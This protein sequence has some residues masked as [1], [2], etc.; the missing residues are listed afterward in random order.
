MMADVKQ[1]PTK[2][3]VLLI[4]V[5]ILLLVSSLPVFAGSVGGTTNLYHSHSHPDSPAIPQE[6]QRYSC[7]LCHINCENSIISPNRFT[8]NACVDL[9]WGPA[10]R[11]GDIPSAHTETFP[12]DTAQDNLSLPH[13]GYHCRNSLGSEE[14]PL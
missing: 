5:C 7:P 6:S 3:I 12:S 2:P 13:T 11:T 8:L 10:N 14:P 4:G 9:D 1:I